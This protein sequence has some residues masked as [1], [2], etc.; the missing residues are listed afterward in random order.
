MFFQ[1]KKNNVVLSLIP[2]TNYSDY[3]TTELMLDS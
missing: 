3:Q 2:N 1:P